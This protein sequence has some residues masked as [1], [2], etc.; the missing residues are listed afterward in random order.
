MS[1]LFF[2]LSI[3]L[4]ATTGFAKC[5][6]ETINGEMILARLDKLGICVSTG[7]ACNAAEHSPSPVLSAMDI[8]YSFAMGSIRFSLGRFNTPEEVETVV[9]AT[10]ET[11]NELRRMS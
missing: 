10:I 5:K 4:L 1:K 8:P 3:L 2:G 6:P 9:A 11:V 7:S